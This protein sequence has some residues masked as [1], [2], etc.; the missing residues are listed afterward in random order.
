GFMLFYVPISKQA[1]FLSAMNPYI[2]VPFSFSQSGS[3]IIYYDGA[4]RRVSG[5]GPSEVER[6]NK[7][8]EVDHNGLERRRLPSLKTP[9]KTKEK[10]LVGHRA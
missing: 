2:C 10:I 7:D 6:N 8:A 9:K 1:H 3:S 5:E 4:D